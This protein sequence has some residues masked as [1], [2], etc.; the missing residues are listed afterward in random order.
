M[1]R[2]THCNITFSDKNDEG[3]LTFRGKMYCK[4]CE[5]PVVEVPDIPPYA[6]VLHGA[7]A[8]LISNSDNSITTNNYY[9]NAPEQVS[10]PYGVVNKIDARLCPH[11]RRWMPLQAEAG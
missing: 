4:Q 1:Y 7:Q 2:C 10:T 3:I 6:G 5:E 11:C 9:G 8:T